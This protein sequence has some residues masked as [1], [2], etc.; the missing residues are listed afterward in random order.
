MA[1]GCDLWPRRL[2]LNLNS[3]TLPVGISLVDGSTTIF[4]GFLFGCWLAKTFRSC[5]MPEKE[6]SGHCPHI[7][8]QSIAFFC[9]CTTKVAFGTLVKREPELVSAVDKWTGRKYIPFS[10]LVP[11]DVAISCSYAVGVYF[12]QLLGMADHLTFTLGGGGYKVSKAF[13]IP[14]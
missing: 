12:G 9:W 4:P 3:S 14:V 5:S 2:P 11:V 10:A 1:Q 8:K 7:S 13:R 6:I